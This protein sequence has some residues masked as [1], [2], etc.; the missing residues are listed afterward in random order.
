[1]SLDYYI[2]KFQKLRRDHKNGG[3]PHKPIL[4][5]AL[6]EHFKEGLMTENK[7]Y[8]TP[9]LIE[10]F[11][12]NWSTLVTTQHDPRF[13]VPFY[14]LKGDGFWNLVPNSGFE[15]IIKLKG[16]MRNIT[17]LDLTLS[18]AF[19]ESSLFDLLTQNSNCNI[20]IQVLLDKYFPTTKH[21]YTSSN[22][23]YE[24]GLSSLEQKFL[25]ESSTQY[26]QEFKNN[27]D[28][29]DKFKR[30][31]VFKRLIPKIYNYTC[32]ISGLRIETTRNIQMIDACHIRQFSEFRDDTINNGFTLCPNLHRAF[33]RGLISVDSNYKVTIS[34][35]FKEDVFNPYGIKQL[36]GKLLILP[37]EKKYQP[38]FENFNWHLNNVFID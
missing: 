17:N 33:D 24:L 18:F 30:G 32:C 1:M 35:A 22:N 16:M 36:E 8:I 4:L 11:K 7:I 21:L 37:K 12:S 15:E 14:H 25:E 9:E 23:K 6:I 2:K 19:L 26:I 3:A 20:L 29:E 27:R 28:D 5:I 34:K 31:A 38:H 10:S 13:A